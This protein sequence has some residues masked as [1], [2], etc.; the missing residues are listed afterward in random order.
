M[1]AVKVYTTIVPISIYTDRHDDITLHQIPANVINHTIF[2]DTRI[3]RN[4]DSSLLGYAF[5]LVI[6]G[7]LASAVLW[8]A[9]R[10]LSTRPAMTVGYSALLT[11]PAVLFLAYGLGPINVQAVLD[12]PIYDSRG[13]A[14]FGP[15][16]AASLAILLRLSAG[17]DSWHRLA[18]YFLK[19]VAIAMSLWLVA[20]G[21]ILGNTLTLQT[22]FGKAL[23]R[24]IHG[25]FEDLQRETPSL[26]FAAIIG[27]TRMPSLDSS[28]Y[29]D[30][31]ILADIIPDYSDFRQYLPAQF[32]KRFGASI[33]TD[34]SCTAR[35]AAGVP[36][37]QPARR[38]VNFDIYVVEDCAVFAYKPES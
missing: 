14:G 15:L 30:F 11:F 6:A 7:A 5:W 16:V 25:R 35:A 17:A 38:H 31:P 8:W 24:E 23:A 29:A 33:P 3:L 9:L 36:P 22:E 1:A 10:I 27:P 13:I 20:F 32:F 34:P 26:R 37:G 19:G 21:E 18:A 28:I 2:I 12:R 4:W